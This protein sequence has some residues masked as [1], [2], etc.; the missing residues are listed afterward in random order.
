MAGGGDLSAQTLDIHK[1]SWEEVAVPIKKCEFIRARRR[2]LT[3]SA[4]ELKEI[5]LNLVL[6]SIAAEDR[7]FI[8]KNMAISLDEAASGSDE[9]RTN[10]LWDLMKLIMY[11]YREYKLL[12]YRAVKNS[13]IDK[14]SIAQRRIFFQYEALRTLKRRLMGGKDLMYIDMPE[15]PIPE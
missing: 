7:E 6:G 5:V 3:L 8:L 11:K 15:Y 9:V 2:F 1:I 13:D 12:F 14:A 4:A 10:F